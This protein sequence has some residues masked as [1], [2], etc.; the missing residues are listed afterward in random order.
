MV[1]FRAVDR[2][3]DPESLSTPEAIEAGAR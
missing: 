3:R 2:G 1:A